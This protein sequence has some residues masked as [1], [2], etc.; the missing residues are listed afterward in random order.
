MAARWQEGG[1]TL[2]SA[3]DYLIGTKP[4]GDLSYL[5][6]KSRHELEFL[7]VQPDLQSV[8]RE[9]LILTLHELR[10]VSV[11]TKQ[12]NGN[13][14]YQ[15]V[16]KEV[17]LRREDFS[18]ATG[19]T[20]WVLPTEQPGDYMVRLRDART[21][22]EETVSQVAFSVVG[23]ANLTRSLERNAELKAQL[24]K[25]EYAPGEKIEVALTAPYAGTGLITI[26]REKVVASSWFRSKGT[27][28][29]QNITLPEGLEGN[30]YLTVTMVRALDSKE[31]YSSPL[32]TTVLPFKINRSKRTVQIELSTPE[33]ARPGR[34]FP[35][36]FK[37]DRPAKIVVYAVDEGILQVA[38]Y[39]LPQPLDHFLKKRALQVSTSQMVDMILPEYSVLKSLAAAGGDG[40][41]DLLAANLN[42]FKRKRE[43]PVVYWSGIIDAGQEEQT[44]LYQVPD[45]FNGTLRVMAVA[46]SESSGG[47]AQRESVL[48]SPFV[49][50]PNVPTFVAPGDH[51][52]V[53]VAV[54][55]MLEGSGPDTQV[56][57]G[58]M[59]AG[60]LELLGE[61]TQKV[62]VAEG[63]E[64]VLTYSFKAGQTLGNADLV[65]IAGSGN[66]ESRIRNSLSV[67]PASAYQTR[68]RSGW[69]E[70][71]KLELPVEGVFYPEHRQAELSLSLLPTGFM[72]GLKLYLEDYPHL[73]SEQ[74][75]SRAFPTL[76]LDD[77]GAEGMGRD[78]R[79]KALAKVMTVLQGRQNDQ[80]AFGLWRT[81]RELQFDFP[82][83][84]AMHLLTE[85]SERGYETPEAMVQRG[86][87]HLE[88]MAR[89]TPGN[90]G[91]ARIQAYAI[92]L[93]TRNQRITTND[94]NRLRTELDQHYSKEWKNDLSALY[95]A[96]SYALLQN[97]READRL[98]DG[99]NLKQVGKDPYDDF[100]STL[101]RDAQYLDLLARHFPE[102]L[103]KISAEDLLKIVEPL[104]RGEFNTH[105]AAYAVLGL[106]SY[107]A[108]QGESQPG[109]FTLSERVVDKV[110]RPLSLS[111]GLIQR[112]TF[113]LEARSLLMEAKGA[114]RVFY[115]VMERGFDRELPTKSV[116]N[117][118][119]IL[120]EYRNRAG[121][122]VES[123][124]L[125]EELEVRVRA[126]CLNR[127]YVDNVAL[128]DLLPGGFE[129]VTESI[130]SA[131]QQS[132]EAAEGEENGEGRDLQKTKLLQPD[133][134]DI[135][136]DR[137]VIYASL[138]P[139]VREFSYRIRAT[140]RGE[141]LV[142]PIQ[143]ESMYRR[144]NQARGV[145][146]RFK[147]LE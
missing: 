39:A 18:I 1:N 105:S 72:R 71:S 81:E 97:R 62:V 23:E 44:L 10:Y 77:E 94:L 37:T 49:I 92:Y 5:R 8:A 86:W 82:S 4:D 124:T 113:S 145:A 123:A 2:V 26:E 16:L 109:S 11:L 46:V 102:R 143:A 91:E 114:Q 135:R 64:S 34:E 139:E 132:E 61:A 52:E 131:Q 89:E 24:S 128:V 59:V 147:V 101:G 99:F 98:M 17:E 136:E 7:A 106:R 43:Q 116:Q 47:S 63:R 70:K 31:I 6:L 129:V 120:R 134:V 9:G 111:P 83:V 67:R 100:Y 80:G 144:E 38:R 126:R 108:A 110:W 146:G 84:Y 73:C 58:L 79:V 30:A 41:E 141:Y 130:R 14:A 87:G 50:Q 121:K 117:G 75:T 74:L 54:A 29:T 28:S 55:N 3:R 112:G 25:E 56:E 21:G 104:T 60:G 133:H 27:A 107:A 122:R 119:E 35:I 65:F 15:S 53:S 19:G 57:L 36:R 115:Q 118:L 90:L 95:C 88:Q 96:A 48:R 76:L 127:D 68:L 137:V 103:K 93:L 51:F 142:P 33:K 78:E 140:N 45:Y 22:S 32:S 12:S 138:E 40:D 125:G 66:E 85:M 69:F 13:L 42:P 20:R